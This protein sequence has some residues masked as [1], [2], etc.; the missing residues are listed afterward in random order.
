MYL[1]IVAWVRK[2]GVGTAGELRKA[3]S[4]LL[5]TLTRQIGEKKPKWLTYSNELPDIIVMQ[6]I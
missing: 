6:C 4:E 3:D 2:C 1:A 5:S